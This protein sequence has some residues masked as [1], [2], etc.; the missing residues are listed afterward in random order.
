MIQ[1]KASGIL[2]WDLILSPLVEGLLWGGGLYL[3]LLAT[4]SPSGDRATAI[5][6]GIGTTLGT[7]ETSHSK[8]LLEEASSKDESGQVER[9]PIPLSLEEQRAKERAVTDQRIIS[10]CGFAGAATFFILNFTTG[11]VPGGFIGGAIGGGLGGAIGVLISA[12]RPK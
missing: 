7:E 1:L 12:L 10:A 6:P 5:Q 9:L 3:G 11:V 2:R 8:R 4:V